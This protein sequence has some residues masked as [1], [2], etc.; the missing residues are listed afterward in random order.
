MNRHV[1]I[2]VVLLIFGIQ[3]GFAAAPRQLPGVRGETLKLLLYAPRPEYPLTARAQRITG[4]GIFVIRVRVKT[5]RVVE[6]RVAQSTGHA[7]LDAAAV[8][9]LSQWRFK[10]GA[11]QPIGVVAPERK[12]PFG[13]EDALFRIPL[14][15]AMR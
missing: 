1:F 4:K 2:V 15:F 8:R 3:E 5:G 6:V 9:A 12:D 11:L 13:K 7:I 10:A 14:D